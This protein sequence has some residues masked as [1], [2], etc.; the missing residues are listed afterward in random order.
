MK[1]LSLKSG[2]EWISSGLAVLTLVLFPIFLYWISTASLKPKENTFVFIK[3]RRKLFEFF[4]ITYKS[5]AILPLLR[6]F[7]IAIVIVF[8]HNY[9]AAQ[10][11][12]LMLLCLINAGLIVY[13]QPL[14][15]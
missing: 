5:F 11:T 3:N 10:I 6:K 1:S 2:I 9:P 8:M 12:I 15:K 4:K 7:V 13:I 14:N